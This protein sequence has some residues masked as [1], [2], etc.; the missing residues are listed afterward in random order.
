MDPMHRA[1][2]TDP[3]WEGYIGNGHG[4]L[5]LDVTNGTTV[6]AKLGLNVHL[7]DPD[8]GFDPRCPLP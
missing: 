7:E 5:V 1:I 4:K 3:D 6:R 2:D 8:D